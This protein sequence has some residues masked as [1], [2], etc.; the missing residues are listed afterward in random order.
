[1]EAAS[2]IEPLTQAGLNIFDKLVA[3]F[4][5]PGSSMSLWSL[6]LALS[7]A[8]VYTTR[9]RWRARRRVSLKV[10]RRALFPRA[11]YRGAST[12]ADVWFLVLNT[13]CTTLLFGW[14]MVSMH[15]FSN[16]AVNSLTDAFGAMPATGLSVFWSSVILT[17]VVFLAY[18]LGYWFDHYTSH[19]IPFFWEFHKV[20]HTA[21]ILSPLTNARLHP[22]DGVKFAN[23][24]ALFMGTGEGVA[25]YLLGN[26][27][28]EFKIFDQNAIFLAFMYL[29]IHLQ[30]THLW[31]AFTGFWG[32]VIVSPAHHQIHHSMNPIHFNKNLGST[33]SVWDWLFGTLHMPSKKRET[34]SFGVEH[35]TAE[36]HTLTGS[37]L[38]PVRDAGLVL[39][40][41]LSPARTPD[42]PSSVRQSA[43]S[44]VAPG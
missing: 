30:H 32:H 2:F 11:L 19:A 27:P 37:L 18:D 6:L 40:R 17:M 8:A 36:V 35:S 42:V 43:P 33:L 4:A 23:I 41:S 14:A 20:H 44:S 9:N 7:F 25:H 13:G 1:V 29:L 38:L 15:F 28:Q 34:L 12:R 10:I 3:V 16:L 22:I 39:W 24:L 21:E 31:I 26:G 5:E